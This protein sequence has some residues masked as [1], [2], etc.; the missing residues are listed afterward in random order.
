M[1]E[2]KII[3]T[4]LRDAHQSLWASRMT[5]AMML[6]VAERMDRAGFDAIDLIGG[7]HFDVC[8]RYL[9]E[10]PWERVR[11]MCRKIT[12]TPMSGMVRSRHLTSFDV[13]SDDLLLLWTERLIAN[14]LRRFRAF[15]ALNDLDAIVS[16]LKHAKELG[17]YTIGQLAYG[18][19]PVH[20]DELYAQKAKELIERAGVDAIMLKDAGG[21]LTPDRI[22]TLVPAIKKVIGNLPLELHTHCTTGL[23]PLVVL[24][25][26]KLGAHPVHT[27]IAPLAN[28]AA[29]P[30]TQTIVRNLRGMGYTVNVDDALINEVGE[31]FRKVA[32]QEG[33]P[34]G[35]PMEFDAFHFEHQVPGGMQSHF[36]NQLAQAGLSH[37]LDEVLRECARIR[38]ELGWP[39][40]ITPLS[41]LVGTQAVLNVVHGE[42]YRIVPDEVKKYA[43]GYYGKLLA[44]VEPAVLDRIIDNGSQSISLEPLPLEPAVPALRKKYP[45]MSDEERLLRYSYA[46]SQVDEMLAA[47][48]IKT[49]Y[50][51]EKPL[52]RLLDEL[53]KRPKLARVYVE[54]KGLR[55][56]LNSKSHTPPA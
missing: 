44:P 24:E 46:G 9:K 40:M 4:T 13:V 42:R 56:E 22:R 33:K 30:A 21:L 48:P 16:L 50:H 2:I 31:H 43:L 49:E 39:I 27:S 18:H 32:Q 5:T 20:T 19:S 28:G 35:V 41:Q 53:T 34:L 36:K 52:V 15:D 37:K 23:G 25:G 3:D 11:L 55:L 26:V 51:F 45:N 6:S 29:Q 10:N 14:G 8:V 17:A 7:S 54:S 1:P 12:R 38:G 47:G